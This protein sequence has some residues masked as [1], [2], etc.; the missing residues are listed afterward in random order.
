MDKHQ[1]TSQ[2]N[3]SAR[4]IRSDIYGLHRQNPEKEQYGLMAEASISQL[5]IHLETRFLPRFV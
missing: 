2:S 3:T 4:K 5:L 1:V